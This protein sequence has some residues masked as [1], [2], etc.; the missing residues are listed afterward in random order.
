MRRIELASK[1][2]IFDDFFQVEEAQLRF[3]KFDGNMSP[4]VRRLCF[5]RGDSVAAILY[6]RQRDS[7]LFVHQ[8]KYPTLAKGPGWIT[9]LMA[10]MIDEDEDPEQ[11]VR[12][13]ILEETGYCV[14]V[15]R[16]VSTFYTS[17]GGTSERI[18]LY[19]ADVHDA[20]KT[21]RGGG[22]PEEN[23]DIIVIEKTVSDARAAIDTGEIVDAKTILG[24][25]WLDDHLSRSR[26]FVSGGK[27]E[28]Q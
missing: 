10:G 6:N 22:D 3:E 16:H 7:M 8:F 4:L 11:A 9:E 25:L 24:I 20:E 12:R 19:Y 18:L 14:Q 2:T 13:E 27:N 23:E 5:E 1:K 28:K 21:E 26:T 17:P 15:L